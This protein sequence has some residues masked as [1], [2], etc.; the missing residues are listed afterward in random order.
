MRKSS[1]EA[2]ETTGD[3]ESSG[4]QF[5]HRRLRSNLVILSGYKYGDIFDTREFFSF[6]SNA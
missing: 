5:A 6:H 2:T 4:V 1:K 3:L